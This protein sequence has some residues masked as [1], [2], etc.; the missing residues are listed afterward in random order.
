[1]NR[2][3]DSKSVQ[4]SQTSNNYTL[5]GILKKFLPSKIRRIIS[6]IIYT[7]WK[8]DRV[9]R[10]LFSPKKFDK[11]PYIIRRKDNTCGLFSYFNNILMAINYAEEHNF[12]PVIDMKNY[13]NAYLYNDE[14]KHVNSWEYYFEQPSNISL[15]DALSCR[16]YIIGRDSI[17]Y[18]KKYLSVERM[19]EL[20]KK[21]I[22]FKPSVLE[23]LAILQEKTQGKRILGVKIRG[24]DLIAHKPKGHYVPPTAEQAITKVQTVMQEKNFDIIYL[25]TEDKNIMEKFKAAFGDKLILPECDYLDYDYNSKGDLAEYNTNRPNDKYLRGLEYLVSI[26]F[27]SKCCQGFIASRSNGTEGAI[28]LSEGFEYLYVFDLGRYE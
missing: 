28:F 9:R 2:D 15:D 19:H 18:Y 8:H 12:I 7:P 24:T 10:N 27:I 14:V 16:K 22:R 26:L 11:I 4:T 5:K 23:K 17:L 3:V 13:P 21:Y 25:A 6:S 20:C 1:M